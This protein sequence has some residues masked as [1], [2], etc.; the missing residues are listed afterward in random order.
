[1]EDLRLL[2]LIGGLSAALGTGCARLPE[3]LNMP[4]V[5]GQVV[6][7][8][9]GQP[10]AGA[11]VF[12]FL[13]AE[14]TAVLTIGSVKLGTRF[15]TAGSNG[16][17]NFPAEKVQVPRQF[18]RHWRLPWTVPTV[19]ALHR[20]YGKGG[21]EPEEIDDLLAVTVKVKRNPLLLDRKGPNGVM[22]NNLSDWC[23]GYSDE[24][25]YRCCD[26]VFGRDAPV[27]HRPGPRSPAVLREREEA[28][29]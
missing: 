21:L 9:S 26:V 29:D 5:R 19:I 17:F 6:D 24:A 4:E 7:A 27:C 13:Y 2:M 28:F 25:F 16:E 8:E 15:Q 20:D 12:I 23:G 10:I 18:R 14:S 22:S 1:M 3:T 11:E